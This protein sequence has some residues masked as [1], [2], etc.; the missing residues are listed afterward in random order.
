MS[1]KGSA[2]LQTALSRLAALYE[3]GELMACS[4]PSRFIDDVADDVTTLRARLEKAEELLREV[5]SGCSCHERGCKHEDETA[6]RM[7]AFLAAQPVPGEPK[8]G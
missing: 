3:N 4:F 5:L 1:V 8:A 6:D 7:L 2:A